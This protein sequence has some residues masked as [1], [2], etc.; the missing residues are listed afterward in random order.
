M[1]VP[2]LIGRFRVCIRCLLIAI[3][4]WL[5][6]AQSA[7][8]LR[9]GQ[10]IITMGDKQ[11]E[12][13]QKCGEPFFADSWQAPLFHQGFYLGSDIVEEWYYNFGPQRFIRILLFRNGRLILIQTGDYGFLE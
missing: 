3:T 8:A 7:F 5:A 12:V 4:L 11:F 13:L 1:R 6:T 2:V 9:C 10:S